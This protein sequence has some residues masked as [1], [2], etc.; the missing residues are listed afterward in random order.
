[1]FVCH[2]S[3]YLLLLLQWTRHKVANH[4]ANQ[5]STLADLREIVPSELLPEDSHTLNGLIKPED[6]SVS[7]GGSMVDISKDTTADSKCRLF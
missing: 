1:M 3:L 4:V 6:T 5:R 7:H 2:G